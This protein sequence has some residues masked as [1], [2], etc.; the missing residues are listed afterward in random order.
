MGQKLGAWPLMCGAEAEGVAV[1]EWGRS[2][3]RGL[4]GVGQKLG[5]WPLRSGAEAG[6]WPLWSGA[7]AGGVAFMDWG[8][9]TLHQELLG[10]G[11]GAWSGSI[12]MRGI[13]SDVNSSLLP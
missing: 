12:C 4:Y 2:W 5:A 1:K 10:G 3:G 8:Q 7:E 11:L 6:A 13:K 9:G